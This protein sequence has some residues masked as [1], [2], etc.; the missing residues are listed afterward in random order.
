MTAKNYWNREIG[1]ENEFIIYEYL[2]DSISKRKIKKV[3]K[4]FRFRRYS[5]WKLYVKDNNRKREYEQL[6]ELSRYLNH[7]GRSVSMNNNSLY[8]FLVP[9]LVSLI[10]NIIWNYFNSIQ[11]FP[12][13][14]VIEHLSLIP[15]I[16][17][18]KFPMILFTIGTLIMAMPIVLMFYLF[19]FMETVKKA[20]L[21]KSFYKDYKE[22]VDELISD[23]TSPIPD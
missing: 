18:I 11:N 8:I 3:K 14:N 19:L 4:Q 16:N 13:E 20:E 7:Q 23:K 1:F 2:C 21:R 5:A 15:I 22:I 6:T 17:V 12:A 9:F 10:S